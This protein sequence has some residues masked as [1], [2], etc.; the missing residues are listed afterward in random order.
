[1]NKL[2]YNYKGLPKGMYVLFFA[3][4]INRLGDFVMPFLALYLTQKIGM[5]TV[6]AGIIVTI[7]S[8]IIIPA[9]MIGGKTADKFGRKKSY[10]YAQFLSAAALI[11]CAMTKNPHITII[12]LLVSTFFNGFIRPAFRSMM[13]D[14]LSPRQ[15][16]A[17]FSLQYLGINVGVAIGP[18]IAGFLFDN[19]LPM[20]FLGDAL[21]SF[22]ALILVWKN[23][24]ETNPSSV[25]KITKEVNFAEKAEK[26]NVFQMLYKRPHICFF[27]IISIAYSFVY[28]QYNFA[29]PLTLKGIYGNNSAHIYGLL[30]SAN[31]ITV[32]VLTVFITALTK[33][34]HPLTNMIIV[35]ILYAIGFG[36][37]SYIS[38]FSF[39]ILS[40]VIWTSGEILSSISSGVYIANNSPNNYRARLIGISS[41]GWAIG[42]SVS[43]SL[44]GAYMQ[45]HG[46][47][48]IWSLTFFIALI[49]ALLMFGVKIFS[50]RVEKNK[51]IESMI[52][53]VKK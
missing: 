10:M 46:Y 52:L 13:T 30:M 34:N 22:L 21:T 1:M 2:I 4:V 23:I 41:V 35:G 53:G 25:E 17:G 48:S 8:I 31:A 42:A 40:T 16:Q 9:S 39:F 26:G 51:T 14:I 18:I 49:S 27:M 19:M 7:S 12:C 45:I 29:L 32:L 44:S 37:I 38:G 47:K 24:Q 33:K 50:V 43:T 6:A 5:T 28:S 11:P 36:M 20:L 15:R 3:Q